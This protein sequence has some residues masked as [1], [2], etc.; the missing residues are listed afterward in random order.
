MSKI[1]F[2]MRRL[3]AKLLLYSGALSH[4]LLYFEI[5]SSVYEILSLDV[6]PGLLHDLDFARA[7]R[8]WRMALPTH[9]RK[10]RRPFFQVRRFSRRVRYLPHSA[11]CFK[12]PFWTSCY[13]EKED[14]LIFSHNCFNH[15]ELVHQNYNTTQY[16]VK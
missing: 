7:L 2:K 5:L 6:L 8:L 10:R 1:S 4:W 12:A 3:T 9:H 16:K 11:L 13:T 15:I 14:E